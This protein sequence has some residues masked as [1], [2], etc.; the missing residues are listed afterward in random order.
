[1][2]HLAIPL[3]CLGL[4]GYFAYHLVEGNRGIEARDRLEGRIEA[5]EGQL[6][7]LRAVRKRIERDVAL[8]RA[9]RLDPDM[10]DERAR[11][12]LNLAHPNDIV[13]PRPKT[14]GQIGH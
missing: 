14:L 8:M 12:I 1:L 13:I 2:R 10:L 9:E 7:G 5:L 3:V 6:D 4:V 11:A